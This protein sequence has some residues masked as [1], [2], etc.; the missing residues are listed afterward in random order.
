VFS[1]AI[2]QQ[3][4]N[5]ETLPYRISTFH[6]CNQNYLS[7]SKAPDSLHRFELDSDLA[8]RLLE[9]D[10]KDKHLDSNRNDYFSFL[11]FL[12]LDSLNSAILFDSLRSD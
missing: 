12:H 9:Q 6:C 4:P 3:L 7:T 1:N 8:F 2:P 5:C 10:I 11:E